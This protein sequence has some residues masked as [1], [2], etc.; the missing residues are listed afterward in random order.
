MKTS[1]GIKDLDSETPLVVDSLYNVT[2]LYGGT[3]MEIYLNAELEAFTLWSGQILQTSIDLTVGQVL[4]L[5]NQYNFNGVLDDIRIYN[6]PLST[7]QISALYDVSTSVEKISG[8]L[9][10]TSFELEQNFPNPFNPT[11][12]I[13]FLVPTAGKVKM[14]VYDVLGRVVTTLLEREME[15]GRYSVIWEA[16]GRASGVYFCVLQAGSVTLVKPMQLIR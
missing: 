15:A 14:T 16:G 12:T 6:Y 4:P 9:R 1:T 10:P 7:A 2:A 13:R 11:T 8:D 3:D 5:D